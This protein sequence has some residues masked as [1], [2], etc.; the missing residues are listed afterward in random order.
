MPFV[1]RL[2]GMGSLASLPSQRNKQL[3]LVAVGTEAVDRA[4]RNVL[5]IIQV[6]LSEC[7]Q[8][9]YH[10]SRRFAFI[11]AADEV[12]LGT[13]NFQCRLEIVFD[14]NS[15]CDNQDERALAV[16]YSKT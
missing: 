14:P 15:R 12:K 11:Q 3:S 8:L 13:D 1:S 4:I 7:E 5:S 16:S 9:E 6:C 2:G 10:P